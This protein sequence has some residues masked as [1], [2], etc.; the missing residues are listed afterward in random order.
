MTRGS[1]VDVPPG[2]RVGCWEV[3]PLLASGSFAAVYAARRTAPS[4][5]LPATAALKFLPTGTAT[6]RRLTHLRELADREL[7][8]LRR[9]HGTPRLIRL[10]EALT[11]DDPDSPAL[12]GATVLVLEKAQDSLAGLLDRTPCPPR[13]PELLAQIAEGL[14]QLHRAGWVHGDL[15][16]ANV[17]V[18]KDG[19]ARLAD[20]NLAAELDGT[21]AYAPAFATPD[22]TPPELF[23]ST[24]DERGQEIRPTADIWA[25]GVL[26]HL[27]LTGAHP[28]PGGT[29]TARRDAAVRYAQG[30][31]ELRLSPR[32]PAE[33]R[34]V[35]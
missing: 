8:L 5:T 12:D 23:W 27:V 1:P 30:L 14:G 17:L 15:K 29:P 9:L 25:Y 18:M 35:V 11:V 24:L 33:W 21:H 2:Y 10:Y 31:D 20:F 6:P 3:G 22:H 34:E 32:L 4:G 13:G 7:Q 16:P 26:A 28:L 19:S